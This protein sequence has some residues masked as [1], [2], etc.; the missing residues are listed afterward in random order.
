MLKLIHDMPIAGHPGRE[1]ILTAARR[2]CYWPTMRIDIENNVATCASCA[3][4]KGMVNG[5]APIT[6]YLSN[7]GT[8]SRYS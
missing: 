8:P 1:R 6:Q 3:Q 2:T 4:H 7:L 5:P